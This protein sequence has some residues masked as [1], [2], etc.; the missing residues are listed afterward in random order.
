MSIST[1]TEELKHILAT[2]KGLEERIRKDYRAKLI[3]LFGSYVRG[4]QTESSDVDILV[5][6]FEG[7]TLFDL[8]GLADFLEE[9]L[10]VKVDV[11]PVDTV[12]K[13]LKERVLKETLY[14]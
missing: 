11:V 7:A 8:V 2:L 10:N 14:L 1:M 13:E 3:G 5:R 6:F 9:R 12:R 4:E